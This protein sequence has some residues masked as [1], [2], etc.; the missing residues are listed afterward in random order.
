LGGCGI[1]LEE[2]VGNLFKRP[3]AIEA[4]PGSLADIGRKPQV[5]RYPDMVLPDGQVRRIIYLPAGSG[6]AL[7][8]GLQ[9]VP[10]FLATNPVLSKAIVIKDPHANI[11]DFKDWK[12]EVGLESCVLTG[13]LEA[14]DTCEVLIEHFLTSVPNVLIEARVVEVIETDEFG[15]G[16]DWFTLN[17]Q[18]HDFDPANPLAPLRRTD[19]IYNRG[20]AGGGIP[21]LP[22]IIRGGGF[23]PNLLVQLGTIQENLQ[24]DLL[25][26]ALAQLTKIDVVN[27]PN[28][29]VRSGHIASITAGEE[30]PYFTVNVS[31]N[32]QT[33]STSFK[34]VDVS[35]TVI[36]TV[37]SRNRVSLAVRL[38]VAN[39]T[40]LSQ[41]ESGGATTTNPIIANRGVTTTM[42][43][44]DGA[45]VVLGGLITTRKIDVKEKVPLLG[46]IPIVDFL[47]SNRHSEE[48]H[49]NLLFI[50]RPK[51]IAPGTDYSEDTILPPD[52]D[53]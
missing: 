25:V 27:A 20:L 4:S 1:R 51:I 32:N 50:I 43:V 2:T 30:I 42:D 29:A 17:S 31:G 37:L 15:L 7:E 22:G 41:V 48:A 11:A 3:I 14:L 34:Q 13:S 49:S 16:F 45:T 19:S 21:A 5:Y 40:G 23:I 53:K 6:V 8:K 52:E 33:V 9:G 36:P 12:G 44:Q 28:V 18:D 38:R 47:F 24:I 46:D 26:S 35:L 39:I 10:E